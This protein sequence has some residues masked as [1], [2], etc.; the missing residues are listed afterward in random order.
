MNKIHQADLLY[1]S[2][3]KVYQ[4]IYKYMLNVVD[5]ASG[6]NVSRPL[7]MKKASEVAERFR[8][9]Y[10]K[11]PLWNPEELHLENGTEFKSDVNKLMGEQKVLVK[12]ATTKYHHKFTAFRENFN[13]SLTLELNDP[14]ED[15]KT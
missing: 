14:S 6:Y 3:N 5:I 1:W 9:M 7:K 8:D 12:R 15:P 13:K 10:K 2:H 11:G 4:T